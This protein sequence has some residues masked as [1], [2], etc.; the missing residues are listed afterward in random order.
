M[1]SR[2]SL[3]VSTVTALVCP[4]PSP[5]SV[6]SP[7]A[8]LALQTQVSRS[9]LHSEPSR[10]SHLAPGQSQGLEPS[11]RG[12]P[13]QASPPALSPSASSVAFPTKPR[14]FPPSLSA[15]LSPLL[16]SLTLVLTSLPSAIALSHFLLTPLGVLQSVVMDL[17]S[18][19][20]AGGAEA[21]ACDRSY[22]GG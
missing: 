3:T 12:C 19:F 16:A 14:T 6:P 2:I 8:G 21:H 20:G 22:A 5:Q 17:E 10:D 15:F 11:A 13:P 4:G 1:T 7:P 9:S 18:A